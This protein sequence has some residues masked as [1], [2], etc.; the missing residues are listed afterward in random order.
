MVFPLW[1]L[2]G[3]L[4]LAALAFLSGRK[5]RGGP[6]VR[7]PVILEALLLPL[8][9]GLGNIN[10]GF[11]AFGMMFLAAYSVLRRPKLQFHGLWPTALLLMAAGLVWVRYPSLPVILALCVAVIALNLAGGDEKERRA[12]VVSLVDGA[13]L[14]AITNVAIY[15][16]GVR[17]ATARLSAAQS[18]GGPFAHRLEFALSSNGS[19]PPAIAAVFL[20]GVLILVLDADHRR[21]RRLYRVVAS[22]AAIFILLGANYRAPVAI[23]LVV[24][25]SFALRPKVVTRLTPVVAVAVL[26]LPFGYSYV[27][28]ATDPAVALAADHVPYLDR[29]E[30]R[31]AGGL[32]NRDIIWSTSVEHW[33]T[34]P[35]GHR[36]SGYGPNGHEVSGS[37]KRYAHLF[38]NGWANP[39]AHSP[40]SSALQHLYDGGLVGLGL[41]LAGV[42]FTLRRLAR[43]VDADRSDHVALA[44]LAMGGTLAATAVTEVSMAPGTFHLTFWMFLI[45]AAVSRMSRS[46][47]AAPDRQLVEATHLT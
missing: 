38:R 35:T 36:L 19:V 46:D 43:A 42:Y 29:P 47:T 13:G 8:M 32:S 10:I 14:Y 33:R 30:S 34:L 25:A 6:V 7:T 21:Q 12:V 5:P 40:H 41:L 31:R 22:A 20:V 15:L 9:T 1:T 18:S 37:S 24:S 44:A 26:L 16:S 3:A 11:A 45:L 28:G 2:L 23:A 27:K 17:L 4:G 39:G